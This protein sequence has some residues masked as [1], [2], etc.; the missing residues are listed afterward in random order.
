MTASEK[1]ALTEWPQ[2]LVWARFDAYYGAADALAQMQQSDRPWLLTIENAAVVSKNKEGVVEFNETGDRSGLG[3]LGAGAVVG[4]LVGLLFP[5][6]LVGATAAGAAA[7][8]LG[9]RLR[10]AGFEDNALRAAADKLQ[11][12]QSLLLAVVNHKW[13]DEAVRF[14]EATASDAGWAE[15]NQRVADVLQAATS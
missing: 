12:N 4:G 5:P 6:A 11:P 1:G 14:L 3:G 13:A 7:G 10:D 15:L 9:S 2:S 8:G